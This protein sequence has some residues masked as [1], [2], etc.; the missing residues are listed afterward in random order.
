MN[1]LFPIVL[2]LLCFGLAEDEYPYFSD[3]LKQLAFEEK[4]I[5]TKEIKDA[6]MNIL[7]HTEFQSMHIVENANYTYAYNLEITQ[8]GMILTEI[9]FLNVVG[10]NEKSDELLN[11]YKTLIDEYNQ[12]PYVTKK[13]S[14]SYHNANTKAFL[15][16]SRISL[17]FFSGFEL[18]GGGIL[19]FSSPHYRGAI[20]LALGYGS[21]R[22]A[23]K[24]EDE[25][26]RKIVTPYEALGNPP[27]YTQSYNNQTLINLAESYN[28]RI[29]NE[30]LINE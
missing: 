30:I 22:L 16:I 3:P 20:L 21:I 25:I 19:I 6:K 8:N 18:M 9:D 12:S 10:L 24:L 1:K 4:R 28:K 27:S 17:L 14:K 7:E 26:N 11:K 15:E 5:Y 23:M 13:R 2:A 29:Y